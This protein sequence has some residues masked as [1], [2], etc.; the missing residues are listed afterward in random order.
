MISCL[1][2]DVVV[3]SVDACTTKEKHQGL[4]RCRTPVQELAPQPAALD[5][6]ARA[7]VFANGASGPMLWAAKAV[8]R[9]RT[10]VYS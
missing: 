2:E 9:C 7:C 1:P 6:A 5:Q 10:L 3:L 8:G 4:N